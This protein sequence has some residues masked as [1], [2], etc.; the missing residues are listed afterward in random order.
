VWDSV[1]V[2]QWYWIPGT[3][4]IGAVCD[5]ERGGGGTSQATRGPDAT[6]IL[7]DDAHGTA[8]TSSVLREATEAL[9]LVH[10]GNNTATHLATAPVVPRRPD[11]LV[12]QLRA[13]AV[14]VVS[15]FGGPA[16]CLD[17]YR[18]TAV[19]ILPGRAGSASAPT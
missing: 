1:R 9:Q 2:G 15:G 6:C 3:K 8:T 10:D 4:I 5:S 16:T 18:H 17:G 19:P 14:Q 11:A 12:G 7:G 13:R